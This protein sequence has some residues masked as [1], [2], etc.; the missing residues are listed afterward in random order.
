M[1]LFFRDNKTGVCLFVSTANSPREIVQELE[2]SFYRNLELTEASA[3]DEIE[4]VS[5][6]LQT[7]VNSGKFEQSFKDYLVSNLRATKCELM[8]AEDRIT[9]FYQNEQTP[10]KKR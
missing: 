9:K 1:N 6:L 8:R 4:L 5:C 2:N 3:Y 7:I 10:N